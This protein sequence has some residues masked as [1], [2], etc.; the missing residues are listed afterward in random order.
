FYRRSSTYWTRWGVTA[1]PPSSIFFGHTKDVLQKSYPRALK[2]RDWG[3]KF[4]KTY[5]IKEGLDNTLVTSDIRIVHE[6]FVKQFDNFHSRKHVVLGPNL[7]KGTSVHLFQARGARWKRLLSLSAPSFSVGNL[8]KVK[9]IIEDSALNMLRI[10]EERHGNGATFSFHQFFCE[11]SMDSICRLVMGQESTQIFHNHRVVV[12][13]SLF[14]RDFDSL[15]VHL[16]FAVPPLVP[17][18]RWAM[19]TVGIISFKFYQ[20]LYA[21][22]NRNHYVHFGTQGRHPDE[23]MDS[24]DFIDF[25]LDFAVEKTGEEQVEFKNKHALNTNLSVDEVVAQAVVFLLA[26]FDTT[27]N[28]LAFTSWMIASHPEIQRPCQEEIDEICNHESISYDELGRLE[29][30]EAVCK[31]TLRFYPLGTF[32]NSRQ[33]MTDTEVCGMFIE[34]GTNVQGNT[35]G[36][37]FDESIWG[38][39]ADE[40][41]PERWLDADRRV[42]AHAYLAFGIGPR[43]CIGM[44]LAMMEEKIALAHILRKFDIVRDSAEGELRLHGSL[45]VTPVEVPVKIMKRK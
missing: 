18:L 39:D 40:F 17:I 23:M 16:L 13:Q 3:K 9:P 29:Y 5:G 43:I 12:V 36:L 22:I 44:K 38:E 19:E 10:M 15:I 42:P 4:S 33:C 14:L 27:S 6:V 31:E 34:N 20:K 35:Y 41:K 1:V 26:G 11:Y 8:K 2:F 45:T 30:L 28:S 24:K 37:H 7:E 21:A 25:F 32:A